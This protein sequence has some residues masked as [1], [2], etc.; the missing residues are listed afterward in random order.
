MVVTE[1]LLNP[2]TAISFEEIFCHEPVAIVLY[3]NLHLSEWLLS[4]YVASFLLSSNAFSVV[5]RRRS[6][7]RSRTRDA[8]LRSILFLRFNE[9]SLD[10]STWRHESTKTRI[11]RVEETVGEQRSS[12]MFPTMLEHDSR[13]TAAECQEYRAD[14]TTRGMEAPRV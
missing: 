9:C 3:L 12:E 7:R 6:F 14:K 5:E 10:S 4:L 11:F 13:S 1:A 2:K 8:L